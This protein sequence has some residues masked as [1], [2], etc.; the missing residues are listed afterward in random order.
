MNVSTILKGGTAAALLTAT[1]AIGGAQAQIQGNAPVD[2][3]ADEFESIDAQAVAIYRGRVEAVQGQSRLRCSELRVQFSRRAGQPAG[4]V[5]ANMGD[6]QRMT[7]VGPVF[8]VTP[9]QNA[10]SDNAVY[11]AGPETITM[12]GNVVVTQGQNVATGDR[13]V[14][15]TRTNDARL[16]AAG[17]AGSDRVRT[18]LYPENTRPA[19]GQPAP[20]A[21]GQ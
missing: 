2:I 6:V 15:N 16:E 8:Y 12:T 19:A 7:C 11:E 17:R 21:P 1:M 3:S 4:A 10:R 14:I 13:A 18:V 5:A 9:T 20:R